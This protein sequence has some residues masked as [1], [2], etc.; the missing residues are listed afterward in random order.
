MPNIPGPGGE[1]EGGGGELDPDFGLPGFNPISSSP[2]T[3]RIVQHDLS[4][5]LRKLLLRIFPK[6]DMRTEISQH[7]LKAEPETPDE[8][9]ESEG[10]QALALRPTNVPFAKDTPNPRNRNPRR[11]LRMSR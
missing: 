2:R 1:E 7:G 9:L 6:H 10:T 3:N 8:L 4:N 5:L 11:S